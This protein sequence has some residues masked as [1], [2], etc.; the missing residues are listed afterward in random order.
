VDELL[1]DVGLTFVVTWNIDAF[2][3]SMKDAVVILV[4]DERHQIPSYYLRVRAI[5]KTGGIERNPLRQTL[6]L[7][8]SIAWR[9]LLRDARNAIVRLKRSI[10]SGAEGERAAPIYPVPLGCFAMLDLDPLPPIEQRPIDVLFAGYIS[11]VR[12]SIRPSHAARR[13]MAAAISAAQAALPQY[14][15]EFMVNTIIADRKLGPAQ[16]TQAMANAKIA[17]APRGNFD[18][19]FRLFEAA[20]AGCVIVSEPL[21]PRWYYEICPVITI[22]A[23]SDLQGVLSGL[24]TDTAKLNWL[25]RQTRQWWDLTLSEPAIARYIVQRVSQRTA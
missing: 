8:P 5:F 11:D 12:W 23:W 19:T 6:R 14:R 18:E 10:S 16:Y 15:I 17:L 24:L 22:R 21:P 3:E 9:V 13:Q 7:P 25:S 4:G 1:P 20:K 2:D